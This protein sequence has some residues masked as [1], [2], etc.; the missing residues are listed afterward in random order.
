M[1]A[2]L[3]RPGGAK[4]DACAFNN[5]IFKD[6][7]DHPATIDW[8]SDSELIVRRRSSSKTIDREITVWFG[9]HIEYVDSVSPPT[10]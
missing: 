7:A 8:K 4:F 1:T 10:P 2:V 9:V 3:L 5:Y 6:L